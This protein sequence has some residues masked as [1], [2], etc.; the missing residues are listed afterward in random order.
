M[1]TLIDFNN[2]LLL[3]ALPNLLQDKT[4][5]KNIVYAS[6]SLARHGIEATCEITVEDVISNEFIIPRFLKEDNIRNER[7]LT[8]AEV[9]TP[10]WL[11]ALQCNIEDS[12][13][14]GCDDAFCSVNL[15]TREYTINTD[16]IRFPEGK[17]W[18]DYIRLNR[19]ELTCGEAPY[20][21]SR[22]DTAFGTEIK[23]SDRAGFLDRKLRV[24]SENT[25]N[26]EEWIDCAGIALKH[27][28]GFD[29]QG[30]NIVLARCNLL[31]DVLE[32]YCRRWG[33]DIPASA[34]KELANIISWN[35][36]QMD[37]KTLCIP[38][39]EVPCAV[40]DWSSNCKRLFREIKESFFN[41]CIGNPPYQE[42]HK[43]SPK[44]KKSSFNLWETVFKNLYSRAA[45]TNLLI[46]AKIL[47]GINRTTSF[48]DWLTNSKHF[49][50]EYIIPNKGLFNEIV[51]LP[52]L[53]IV[54]FDNSKEVEKRIPCLF[55]E[56]EGLISRLPEGKFT[57][58]LTTSGF[59]FN[60]FELNKEGFICGTD[61]RIHTNVLAKYPR[62]FSDIPSKDSYRILL[63]T[64]SGK[65]AWK[66]VDKKYVGYSRLIN[67]FNILIPKIMDNREFLQDEPIDVL[68]VLEL[69]RPKEICSETFRVFGSFESL[70]EAQNCYK[71]LS[72]KFVRAIV[73]C[74]KVHNKNSLCICSHIPMQDFSSN[75]VIDWSTSMKEL[76]KQL[77]KLYACTEKEIAFIESRIAEKPVSF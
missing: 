11:C 31:L 26:E 55:S 54:S 33:K 22:Y 74:F 32:H 45:R 49:R 62:L 44:R 47:F 60:P 27:I 51:F 68:G 17:S 59:N 50:F 42:L 41:S 25:Y 18:L 71:Y 57:E 12:D 58:E 3:E 61:S 28:Y 19:L 64:S 16:K 52:F 10:A 53:S 65:R 8:D 2:P 20:L 56:L 69:L 77:Y 13:W 43:N 1:E 46:P 70:K 4:T 37:G 38:D 24:I 75:S 9:F 21:A 40:W 73:G 23:V 67:S 6:K 72:T 29:C 30:D 7:V 14:L 35:I 39:S 5:K 63:R 15:K 76:D 48:A 34:V 36:I 66:Y